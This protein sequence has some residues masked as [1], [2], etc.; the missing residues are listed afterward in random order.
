MQNFDLHNGGER[1]TLN[2]EFKTWIAWRNHNA[3]Y[4][5]WKGWGRDT[6]LFGII[7]FPFSQGWVP[8]YV[9]WVLG[10]IMIEIIA[11]APLQALS[12]NTRAT[13]VIVDFILIFLTACYFEWRV[14]HYSKL[15]FVGFLP[16]FLL[17]VFISIAYVAPLPTS[18]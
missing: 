8:K 4:R 3:A 1:R 12:G 5:R 15:A 6:S 13:L 11:L 17:M 2:E 9:L 14:W 18:L 10:I 7:G 16:V